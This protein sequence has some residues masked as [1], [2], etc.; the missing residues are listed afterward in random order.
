MEVTLK[1]KQIPKY[2]G[3]IAPTPS[4]FLHEGHAKT[5]QVAWNRAKN[6][7]G[8]V[9][10]RNDDL[11]KSRCK[12]EF[13]RLAMKDLRGLKIDWDE[14][15]DCGGSYGP[16]DQSKRAGKYL[17]ALLKLAEKGYIYPCDKSRKEIQSLGIKSK[18][19][20]EYLF[21]QEFRPTKKVYVKDQVSLKTNWRFRTK[22][23]CSINFH[24]CRRGE[25][26]FTVG[27][28]LSDFLV[29]RKEGIAS[30]ELATVVDDYLMRV[31]EIVRGEDLLVSTAR[32]CL[33]FDILKWNRP[34]FYHCKL[35]V[36]DT[37]RKLS[38]GFRNF[39]KLTN[40]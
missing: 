14:G 18:S 31:T 12:K 25:Q 24:D 3:R 22:W 6:R 13:V 27:E 37:G 15:P 26:H 23:N 4:G 38:K 7:N 16:Y 32:Q 33:L 34:D 30:Y 21:P 40:K 29:W 10:Y 11:D 2:R 5:F 17:T 36:D 35:I 20:K 1:H 19:Y 9:I 28:D 8:S 39:H